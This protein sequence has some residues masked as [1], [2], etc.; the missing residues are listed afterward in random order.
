MVNSQVTDYRRVRQ[1]LIELDTRI[2]MK[3]QI[4]RQRKKRIIE[5]QMIQRDIDNESDH[6]K[7]Q[8]LEVDLEQAVWDIQMYDKKE[9]MCQNEMNNFLRIIKDIVPDFETLE[10][11]SSHDEVQERNYWITRMAK[12]AAM[13]LNTIGRISQGNMDS[14]LMMPLED[15]K[16]TI[17]V[18][19]KYNGILGKGIQEIEHKVI[20]QIDMDAKI[21]YID[22]IMNE[23]LKLENKSSGETI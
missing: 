9:V 18:A 23:G 20:N 14:I 10:K 6:L 16:E 21:N 13:D 2:G 17:G 7:K 4:E 11:Y 22:Q 5:K 15:I 3:K 12:Q 1:A 8:L 19:I